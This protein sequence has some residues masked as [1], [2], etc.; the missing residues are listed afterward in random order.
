MEAAEMLD[1]LDSMARVSVVHLEPREAAE[2]A[3]CFRASLLRVE[4]CEAKVL[5]LTRRLDQRVKR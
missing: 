4:K 5:E 2:M 1:R 3:R